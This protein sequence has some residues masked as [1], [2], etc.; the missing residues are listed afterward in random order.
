MH[1]G[2]WLVKVKSGYD[3]THFR[4]S[5]GELVLMEEEIKGQ[6]PPATCRKGLKGLFGR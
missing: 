3:E 2:T 4:V 1:D 5:T 6:D